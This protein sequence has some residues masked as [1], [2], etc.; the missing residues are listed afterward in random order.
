MRSFDNL[1]FPASEHGTATDIATATQIAK[2]LGF[3][4]VV[5]PADRGA[6]IAVSVGIAAHDELVNAFGK[7]KTASRNGQ[8]LVERFVPGDDHRISVFNGKMMRVNR[9]TPP[10]IIGDGNSSVAELIAEKNH[11]LAKIAAASGFFSQHEIDSEMKTLLRK[12]GFGL[13][14]RPLQGTEL[15]LRNTSNLHTGGKTEDVTALIHPDNV[16]MAESIAQ[17]IHMDA[18]GIDLITPD[19]GKPWTEVE[20]AIIEI[21]SNPGLIDETT[22]EKILLEK[23]PEGTDGRIP[24]ILIVDGAPEF[25]DKIVQHVLA[26]SRRVG[27]TSSCLTHLAG[28]RRFKQT[29]NLP[30]RIKSLLLDANCEALI[31]SCTRDEIAAHGLPHTIYDLALIADADPLSGDMFQL[32]KESASQ[33]MECVSE[34]TMHQVILPQ[35]TTIMS[36]E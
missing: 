32:I 3:P 10:K 30:T 20:C 16:A 25:A 2:R 36:K 28:Q 5:K 13:E 24:S 7:A 23:F 17:T 8:V 31:V 26:T 4:L 14:D 34:E 35:I 27:Y 22:L 1:G 9:L 21:N 6:G 19:I 33:I 11:S 18:I 29:A 12:Q 15:L